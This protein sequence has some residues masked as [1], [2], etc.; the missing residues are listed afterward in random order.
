M[1]KHLLISCM[2]LCVIVYG[3]SDGSADG[4]ASSDQVV[5]AQDIN[6]NPDQGDTPAPD[7]GAETGAP[8]TTTEQNQNVDSGASTTTPGGDTTTTGSS[9]T[10]APGGGTATQA[11]NQNAV[12]AAIKR[13]YL[14]CHKYCVDANL[15]NGQDSMEFTVVV[16]A[17][18]IT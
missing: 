7:G 9:S 16:C 4:A 8:P 14:A 18:H 13:I 11:A 10:A 12:N 15:D 2:L 17:S 5:S 3:Q 6:S 1:L